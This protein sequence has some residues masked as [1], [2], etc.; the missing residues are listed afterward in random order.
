MSKGATPP[1]PADDLHP[2]IKADELDAGDYVLIEAEGVEI[3]IYNTDEGFYA[4]SNY[5][6][7][8]GAPICEGPLAGTI[9]EDERGELEYDRENMVVSCPWHGWEFDVR[10]GQHIS[11]PRYKLPTFDV[12][13]EDGYLYVRR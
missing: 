5:C 12:V 13:L 8:Q 2:V 3:A 7:H 10:D 11:R 4:V 9:T 1:A 6:V